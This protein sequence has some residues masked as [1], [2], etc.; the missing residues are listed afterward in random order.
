M[1]AYEIPIFTT[2]PTRNC[3][4]IG[5]VSYYHATMFTKE[6][7]GKISYDDLVQE[8][9]KIIAKKGKELGA[10]AIYGLKIDCIVSSG[11]MGAGWNYNVYGTAVKYI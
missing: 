8:L 7:Y 3:E 10:D 11:M 9:V 5:I 2:S 1:N 6:K 4:S